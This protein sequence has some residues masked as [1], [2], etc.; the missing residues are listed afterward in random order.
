ARTGR[1]LV[2]VVHDRRDRRL[3]VARTARARRRR[4]QRAVLADDGPRAAAARAPCA[5]R[6]DR[7][8]RRHARAALA[9]PVSPLVQSRVGIPRPLSQAAGGDDD[10][11]GKALVRIAGCGLRIGIAAFVIA[12]TAV[13]AQHGPDLQGLWTNGTLTPLSRPDALGDKAVFTEA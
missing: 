3:E 7:L 10:G 12:A 9:L 13:S 11:R 1:R 5:V 8:S 2:H 6:A 4:S